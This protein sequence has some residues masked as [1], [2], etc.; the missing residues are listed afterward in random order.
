MWSVLIV[1]MHTVTWITAK[2]KLL[3]LPVS[4][5]KEEKTLGILSFSLSLLTQALHKCFRA[6]KSSSV[7]I[8]PFIQS[9]SQDFWWEHF[10]CI[11]FCLWRVAQGNVWET[12]QWPCKSQHAAGCHFTADTVQSHIFIHVNSGAVFSCYC[13]PLLTEVG[14]S[15]NHKARCL[16]R[17][18]LPFQSQ[19]SSYKANLTKLQWEI[20]NSSPRYITDAGN[21]QGRISDKAVQFCLLFGCRFQ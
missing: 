21:I 11:A 1:T 8:K 17:P 3:I 18:H 14:T 10:S 20:W 12:L 15:T 16:T 13:F 6:L 4:A 7:L 2:M 19:S 9:S 5:C